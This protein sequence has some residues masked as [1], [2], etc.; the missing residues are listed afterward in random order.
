MGA[1]RCGAAGAQ[2]R[3]C[4]PVVERSEQDVY[5]TGHTTHEAEGL[6]R[7]VGWGRGKHSLAPSGAPRHSSEGL[8]PQGEPGGSWRD[9]RWG[10][11]EKALPGNSFQKG[12]LSGWTGL[13]D[14]GR[15]QA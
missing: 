15:S 11:S 4:S 2:D 3:V 9:C 12:S 6:W 10:R 8:V 1:W 14:M 13:S 7:D 5:E